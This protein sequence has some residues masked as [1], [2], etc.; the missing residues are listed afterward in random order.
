M[1]R[2]PPHAFSTA[3]GAFIPLF[4]SVKLWLQGDCV[5][6][7]KDSAHGTPFDLTVCVGNPVDEKLGGSMKASKLVIAGV[8][9]LL[10]N[11]AVLV[12][13]PTE[14]DG[15]S[16]TNDPVSYVD[17]YLPLSTS[18]RKLIAPSVDGYATPS[19][20]SYGEYLYPADASYDPDNLPNYVRTDLN[21]DGYED[22]AFLFS[23]ETESGD[24]WYLTT[25]L[26]VVLGTWDGLELA[27]DMTLGTV[28][29]DFST[30][31][32]EYWALALMPAGTHSLE[33]W[34]N[35]VKK[36]ESITLANDAVY[37]ASLDPNE[38][39][40][41][42]ASGSTVYESDWLGSGLGKKVL[43]KASSDST[44]RIIPFV[45]NITGRIGVRGIK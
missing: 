33:T 32:E 7:S 42:Y 37:L 43:A 23:S 25:K 14:T 13:P 40:L 28:T 45:K 1:I 17:T 27:T 21:G 29:A 8:V 9:G 22:Y 41:M 4:F 30:P 20:S 35:G 24:A 3:C 44:K 34:K 16:I 31:V 19:I 15:S 2:G 39:R 38:E 26:L 11:C 18:M 36:T 6:E 10:S 12:A 5:E